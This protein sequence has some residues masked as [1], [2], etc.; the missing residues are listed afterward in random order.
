MPPNNNNFF[1]GY[2]PQQQQMLPQ[3]QR[4]EIIT[5]FV[6]GEGG[7][8][9]YPVAAGNT[10]FLFD[11][12]AGKF[13]IKSTDANCIP[14]PMREFDFS[15]V[16]KREQPAAGSGD[17]VSRA[18]FTDLANAVKNLVNI[19]GGRIGNESSINAANAESSNVAA[20]AK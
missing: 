14:Q 9:F 6:Q 19:I 11:F 12:N 15:E 17:V 4:N 7:A 1:G 13:W 2:A 5:T 10:V 3:Q 8:K 16:I 18:E 20:K